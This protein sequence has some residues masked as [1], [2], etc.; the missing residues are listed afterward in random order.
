[1]I[2]VYLRGVPSVLEWIGRNGLKSE[3]QK[4]K[5]TYYTRTKSAMNFCSFW[6][7]WTAFIEAIGSLQFP[8]IYF[9]AAIN[10]QGLIGGCVN[11]YLGESFACKPSAKKEQIHKRDKKIMFLSRMHTL[12]RLS[13][14]YQHNKNWPNEYSR[15]N[16]SIAQLDSQQPELYTAL[17]RLK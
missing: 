1:M 10:I 2:L 7:D 14:C 17:S 8:L 4:K 6:H 3:Y 15:D 11:E 12:G 13:I 5:K 9:V 16:H